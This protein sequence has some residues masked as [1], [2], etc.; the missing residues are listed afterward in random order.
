MSSFGDVM[1]GE[2][3]NGDGY[4][5]GYDPQIRSSMATLGLSR[6]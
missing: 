2:A 1:I 3:A 4:G 5:A 6:S